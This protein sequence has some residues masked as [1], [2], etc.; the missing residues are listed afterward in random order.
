MKMVD[1]R[2]KSRLITFGII[3]GAIIIA[4]IIIYLQSYFIQDCS[5]E[6]AEC[7][8]KKATLYVQ[9]GCHYCEIQE[10]KFGDK[11]ELL[12][13]VD[14]IENDENIQKCLDAEITGTPSWMINGKLHEGVYEIEELKNMTGC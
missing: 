4:G 12:N 6:V 8:G 5:E 1:E 9:A 10:D 2:V 7:I 14:C 13:I 3:V 11:L